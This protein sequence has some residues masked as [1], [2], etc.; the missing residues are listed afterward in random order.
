MRREVYNGVAD[1]SAVAA[2]N[3]VGIAASRVVITL[4]ARHYGPFSLP[5][6]GLYQASMNWFLVGDILR[7]I[8]LNP[9]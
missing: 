8:I 6:Q 3:S 9:Y 2:L 4:A 1:V 5:A 7:V